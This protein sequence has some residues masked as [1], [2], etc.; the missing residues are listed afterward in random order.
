[1]PTRTA[2][3]GSGR[4]S[5]R[6]SW[7]SPS[8]S[9]S[10]SLAIRA[11]SPVDRTVP[12]LLSWIGFAILSAGAFVGGDVVFG[13]GN[14]VNRHAWRGS[15]AKWIAL[16][17]D[18]GEEI[19]ENQP[20]RAKLGI[21][22]LVLVRQGETVLAL[23]DQCAHAGGPLSGRQDRGRDDPVPVA[24]LAL[25]PRRRPSAARS[26]PLRPA[27]LRGPARRARLGGPPDPGLRRGER[28]APSGLSTGCAGPRRRA[29]GPRPG[30]PGRCTAW[31]TGPCP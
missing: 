2:S 8:S 10:A 31:R 23:H 30:W 24:R 3:P 25:P 21:N 4:R 12:V 5:T 13:L 7:S 11:G 15:G 1:M 28:Q 29:A 18:G 27:D 14:M 9:T 6:R 20:V 26:R 19:P 16:E 22:T 17:P